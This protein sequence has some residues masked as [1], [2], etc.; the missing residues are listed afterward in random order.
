MLLSRTYQDRDGCANYH[1]FVCDWLFASELL[2]YVKHNHG[3]IWGIYTCSQIGPGMY[4]AHFRAKDER[5]NDKHLYIQIARSEDPE[6]GWVFT[7]V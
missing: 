5:D 3:V 6:I 1:R 7:E 2:D 4:S